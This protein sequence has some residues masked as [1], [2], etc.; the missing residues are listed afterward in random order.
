MVFWME[1]YVY[2]STFAISGTEED[3][4][5]QSERYNL[6]GYKVRIP[7]GNYNVSLLFAEKFYSSSGS[8][9]FDVYIEGNP[10]I[11]NLDVFAQVGKDAAFIK[12]ITNVNISDEELHIQFAD[13]VNSAFISGIIITANTTGINDIKSISPDNFKVE[14]NY[15]NPFNGKTVINFSLASPDN[16]RLELFNILG[17]QIFFED[18]GLVP[19]GSHNYILDT[20]SLSNSLLTS[21]VYFYVFSGTRIR[22]TRKLVLLN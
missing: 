19:S 2:P 8:R 6:V 3:A 17:E 5:F 10:V 15:P 21:G 22:E 16:L 18:L 14:Q 13:I 20:S 12:E 11:K 9:V 1:Q 4:I 7:N